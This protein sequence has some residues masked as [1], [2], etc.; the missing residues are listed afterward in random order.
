MPTVG[1]LYSFPCNNVCKV[2]PRTIMVVY[3][4]S[5]ED[6]RVYETCILYPYPLT[7][8]EEAHLLKE[9]DAAFA[10]VHAKELHKDKWGRRGLAYTIE[11]HDQGNFLIMYHE[12]EPK[13]LKELDTN[14]KLIQGIMRHMIVKP[15]KNYEVVDFSE[16]FDEWQQDKVVA[17]DTRK[18]EKEETLKKR[19]LEKQKTSNKPAKKE[20]AKKVDKAKISDDID[21]LIASD[22]LTL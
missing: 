4:P 6:V 3:T 14:L 10:E 18:K 1:L 7:Q 22:D 13:V 21:N 8:K 9:I 5:T 15:P 20:V 19:M 17:E 16:G 12:M 11:D 2:Y